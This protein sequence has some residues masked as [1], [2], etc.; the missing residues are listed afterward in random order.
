ML[1]ETRLVSET[2]ERQV[3]AAQ[4]WVSHKLAVLY[5]FPGTFF[6]FWGKKVP[7]TCVFANGARDGPLVFLPKPGL[8]SS[9]ALLRHRNPGARQS[10]P[11][12]ALHPQTP[13]HPPAAPRLLLR[14]SLRLHPVAVRPHLA[15]AR[16]GCGMRD[17]FGSAP[18]SILPAPRLLPGFSC[19]PQALRR[20]HCFSLCLLVSNGNCTTE[21]QY[22]WNLAWGC[23]GYIE[24]FASALP[25]LNGDFTSTELKRRKGEEGG[26][27]ASGSEG[28]GQGIT[29]SLGRE[30]NGKDMTH[31]G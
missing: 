12:S 24:V 28:E 2:R 5:G 18:R 17:G 14:S 16:A 9:C 27:A 26:S 7:C 25:D 1:K 15:A 8:N 23:F 13:T 22:V 29:S 4:Q 20:Q 3:R 11:S 10:L 31:S 21:S 19:A 30:S 6:L